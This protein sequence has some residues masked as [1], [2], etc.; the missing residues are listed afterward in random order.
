MEVFM[1]AT[2]QWKECFLQTP[3]FDKTKSYKILEQLAFSAFDLTNDSVDFTA[4]IRKYKTKA[5]GWKYM[6]AFERVDDNILAALFQLA[7]E[8]QVMEQMKAMQDGFPVNFIEGFDSEQR[9]VLHTA[10]RDIFGPKSPIPAVAKAQAQA[11]K[12]NEKLQSFLKAIDGKFDD[13][14]FVG[15]G[16][17]ELG[18]RAL[19]QSLAF[20]ANPD[21]RVHFIGNVDPDDVAIV[22]KKVKLPRALVVVISK[23]GTTL[24]TQTN[25]EFLRDAFQKNGLNSNEHFVSVTMPKTPMD[26]KS[27]Y[28]E[29]FYLEDYVGGRYSATSMVGGVLLGFSCGYDVFREIL[30]GAHEMDLVARSDDMAN[31]PPLLCALIGVWNRNFLK[32]PTCAVIP[33][34]RVLA[35]FPAHLQQNR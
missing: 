16:G 4:R 27:R 1:I 7:K 26:D 33:Y 17:S 24:E 28:L 30:K 8:R 34:S 19:F 12:E 21:R 9:A 31:N 15:I 5:C 23:S 25:E 10:Q 32:F 6:Y 13:M 2:D 29:C 20:Y 14:I 35:R 18:P 11:I 3:A 22:L